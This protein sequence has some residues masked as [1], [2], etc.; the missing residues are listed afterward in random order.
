[1]RGSITNVT[2][3]ASTL[4]VGNSAAIRWTPGG[5]IGDV[6]IYTKKGT[7]NWVVIPETSTNVTGSDVG[8]GVKEWTWASVT[9]LVSDN[10]LFRVEDGDNANVKGD[11]GAKT[12]KGQLTVAAPNVSTAYSIGDTVSV[13]WNKTGSIGTLTI[14]YSAKGDF[15][16]TVQIANTVASGADGLNTYGGIWFAPNTVS[17]LYKIRV[18]NDDATNNPPPGT[19]LTDDSDQAFQ[20]RPK[21]NSIISPSGASQ[22]FVGDTN[23]TITWSTTSGLKT[24]SSDPKVK[25]EYN[26]DGGSF[27]LL[28]DPGSGSLNSPDGTNNY[29]WSAIP[30]VKSSQARIKITYTDYGENIVTITSSPFKLHPKILVEDVKTHPNYTSNGIDGLEAGTWPDSGSFGQAKHPPT[31]D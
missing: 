23:R 14:E 20:V 29:T 28:D 19:E 9:D 16:D 17:E 11:S 2:T 25:I 7:D 18:R 24:D 3:T 31:H 4:V 12:V 10:V 13:Q 27:N 26:L 5:P 22:W 21:F 30:N 8:G 15:S 1:M 6:K